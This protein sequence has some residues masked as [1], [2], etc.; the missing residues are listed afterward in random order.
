MPQ[1]KDPNFMR[2]SIGTTNQWAD[3][4]ACS[5]MYDTVGEGSH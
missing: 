4:H 2:V 1:A 3:K 5:A